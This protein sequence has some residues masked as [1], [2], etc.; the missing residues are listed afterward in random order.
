ML[1]NNRLL[2][3]LDDAQMAELV[4]LG[5]TVRFDAGQTVFT[6]GDPGDCLYAI[7]SG[8]IAISTSSPDGKTMLLN[9]LNP[10][11]VLG[12]IA[13]LDGKERTAAATA[14]HRS[15]MF[16]LDRATFISFLERHPKLCIQMME[17]LCERLRWVSENIEDAVFHDVPRRLARRILFLADNY[18][19]R[20]PAGVRVAQHVSQDALAA[21]L[22]VS[23]EMVNR[24][25]RALRSSG[26]IE[27]AKGFIV[28]TGLD[29]LKD[30]AG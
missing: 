1:R 5:W 18:G 22:G 28:I 12:E 13:L 9:L 21:M 16:R 11:D 14:Q 29:Q 2:S 23:R 30:M 4:S 6:K 17:M 3:A 10:G 20:T 26:A 15:E 7:L 25:L 19:Q 8:Q 24:S 27:Y